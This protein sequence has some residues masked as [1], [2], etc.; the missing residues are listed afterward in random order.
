MNGIKNIFYISVLFIFLFIFI[1]FAFQWNE[2]KTLRNETDRDIKDKTRLVALMVKELI[3]SGDINT[4]APY[5]LYELAKRHSI[6]R[7]VISDEDGS[8]KNDTQSEAGEKAPSWLD[9]ETSLKALG[10]EEI[11]ITFKKDKSLMAAFLTRVS[12]GGGY[13]VLSVV[14]ER[15]HKE[16][17]PADALFIF[18]AG[19]VLFFGLVYAFLR[20]YSG[21]QKRSIEAGKEGAGE[22]GFVVDTFHELVSKLKEKEKELEALRSLAE[23]RA[24]TIEDYNE[25]ILQSVPSGVISMDESLRMMKVNSSAERI[26]EVRAEDVVGKRLA[27]VFKVPLSELQGLQTVERGD[28]HYTTQSGKRMRLGFSLSPLFDRKKNPIGRLFVFTDLTELKALE[29]QAALRQRLSSLGEMAA[30]IAHELRNPMGVIAGY[31]KILSKKVDETLMPQVDAIKKEVSGMDAIINDF[32]SFAKPREPNLTDVNLY[33]LI[34]A[35]ADSELEGRADIRASINIDRAL[36][37]PLDN[38]LMRQTFANLIRNAA[39]AMPE[40]GEIKFSSDIKPDHV[41][42]SV[43]DTGHGIPEGIREKIFLPFFTTKENGTGLGLA[44]VHRIVASHGG[45][46]DVESTEKGTTFRLR[47]P[48]KRQ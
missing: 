4:S 19:T 43:S 45:S 31:T 26:L 28:L 13:K 32:L 48:G 2:L 15:Q 29:S 20:I 11:Y 33:E 17:T 44:I 8:I 25:N 21:T 36:T 23:E 42:I 7:I 30:G 41:D 47:L 5:P 27:E 16:E 24:E 6:P 9:K 14:T 37:L 12:T 40:G 35:S 1:A 18:A 3:E 39:D 38:I 22:V 10:G 46:I 34:E